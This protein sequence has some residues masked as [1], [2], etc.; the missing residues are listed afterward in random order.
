[1]TKQRIENTPAQRPEKI[2]LHLAR[3]AGDWVGKA[4]RLRDGHEFRFKAWQELSNWLGSFLDN[5]TSP[6][7]T[8]SRESYNDD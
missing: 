3:D 7:N 6:H 4:T 2:L 5:A 1:M 8:D